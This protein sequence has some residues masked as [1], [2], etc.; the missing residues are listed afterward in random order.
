MNHYIWWFSEKRLRNHY[1]SDAKK[2]I[3]KK[4]F[5]PKKY[6]QKYFPAK[7]NWMRNILY[8]N[9]HQTGLL[10]SIT[11]FVSSSEPDCRALDRQTAFQ[12]QSDC[13]LQ[14][15]CSL[16]AV[17]T[18]AIELQTKRAD[19]LRRLMWRSGGNT[20]LLRKRLRVRFPHSENICVHEHVCLYW[21]WVFLCVICM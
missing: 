8:S 15:R 2:I 6:S 5:Y 19:Q 12:L 1:Y 20:R 18:T 7:A 3:P 16:N 21:V 9:Y 17:K 11:S 14:F 10:S 13:K 4:N